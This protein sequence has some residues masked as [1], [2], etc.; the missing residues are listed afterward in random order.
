M[1]EKSRTTGARP[2]VEGYSLYIGTKQHDEVVYFV[3]VGAG[4]GLDQAHAVELHG[5][6]R[7]E[8]LCLC[9]DGKVWE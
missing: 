4:Y 2:E 5:H 6:G 1:A 9:G 7:L 8:V 3:S